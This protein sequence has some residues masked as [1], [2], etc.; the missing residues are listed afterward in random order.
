VDTPEGAVADV[1]AGRLA[2]ALIVRRGDDGGL[3]FAYHS[4]DVAPL[5]DATIL[6]AGQSVSLLDWAETV[7][8][9]ADVPPYRQP[10]FQTVNETLAR[11][12]GNVVDA[13]LLASRFFLAIIFVV[14]IFVALLIYGMW[15]ASSA[16]AEKGSRI[17]ELLI[18]AASPLQ[19]MLGKVAGTGLAGLLQ[20]FAFLIPAVVVVLFQGRIEDA[21]FGSSTGSAPLAA[22]TIPILVAYGVFFVLGFLLYAFLYAAAGS[23]VSGLDDLQLLALPM[24]L[25]PFIG[26][27]AAILGLPAIGSPLVVFLSYVPFFSPFVMLAR[28]LVGRV[29][30]WEVGLSIGL[31]VG[32][33]VIAAILAS[34]VYRAGVLIYGQ[35]TSWRTFLRAAGLLPA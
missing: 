13:Q 31:L 34:R 4:R 20:Y 15:V 35:R 2:A 9:A 33:I 28:I 29:E 32:A 1:R 7:R 19:L 3:D 11:D 27:L 25:L 12:G 26:C 18:A 8:E 21:L 14:M 10:S 30:P 16:A 23:I 24:S 17:M 6:L 5:R 22:V